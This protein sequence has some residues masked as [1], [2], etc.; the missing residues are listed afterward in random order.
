MTG[1]IILALLAI[2][3]FIYDLYKKNQASE[4]KNKT[5]KSNKSQKIKN[6]SKNIANK[7]NNNE[8]R[9]RDLYVNYKNNNDLNIK[10]RK[11]TI[12]DRE[13]EILNDSYIISAD[14][15]VNDIIFAEILK[16]PKSKR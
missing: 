7:K 13:K 12:V 9:T 15:I 3:Q 10:K 16:K 6:K 14:K 8:P 2:A 11:H 5:Q 4:E 1:G